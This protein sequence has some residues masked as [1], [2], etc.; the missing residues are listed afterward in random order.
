MRQCPP[1]DDNCEQGRYCPNRLEYPP[2][3]R[4]TAVLIAVFLILS[5]LVYIL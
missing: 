1:C 5:L 3:P 2:G 4:T